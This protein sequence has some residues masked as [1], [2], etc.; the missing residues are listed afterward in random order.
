MTNMLERAASRLHQSN[1]IMSRAG[2]AL[3]EGGYPA[4]NDIRNATWRCILCRHGEACREWLAA[5]R[6]D[7]PDFC[8]NRATFDRYRRDR[9]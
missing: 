3:L 5:G 9:Q 6:R 1:E 8:P 4:E 2:V 7:V